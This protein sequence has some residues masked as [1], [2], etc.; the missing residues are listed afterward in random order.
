MSPVLV[1]LVKDTGVFGLAV[2]VLGGPL[3]EGLFL[4]HA[5]LHHLVA[6][7]LLDLANAVFPIVAHAGLFGGIL[8]EDGGIGVHV[9]AILL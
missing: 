7:Q 6:L 8:D 3:T 9:L 2:L 1:H 4:L 5:F